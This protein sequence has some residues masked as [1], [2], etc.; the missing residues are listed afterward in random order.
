[1]PKTPT[2]AVRN[3]L[4]ITG[5]S[6]RLK[7]ELFQILTFKNPAYEDARRF[8][9]YGTPKG[10]PEV[11]CLCGENK[12][13]ELLLPRGT[14][15][16]KLSDES[17]A[18]LDKIDWKDSRVT[19]PVVFPK[20]LLQLNRE[21][22]FLLGHF[23][24]AFKA[25]DRPFG[26][27]LMVAPTSGGK[28]ILQAMIARETKQ[29]TLVLFPTNLA[30]IAWEED[31]VKLFGENFPVGLI[32][33]D[34][35]VI[36]EQFTLASIATLRE[37]KER[38]PEI[39]LK[40]GCVIVDETQFSKAPSYFDFLQACPAKY[41][42]SASATP[43][44][45]SANFYVTASFGQPLK[46]VNAEQK[47]TETS[48]PLSEV[49]LIETLFTYEYEKL[50]LDYNDLL[51]VMVTDE[52]RNHFFLKYII[53]ELRAGHC[54]L[55]VSKRKAHVYVIAQ[56]LL[57]AGISDYCIITGDTPRPEV[58]RHVKALLERKKRCLIATQAVIKVAANINPLDRLF[59]VTPA[60]SQ[61]VEQ[62]VGR[63]R[64]KSPG[65]TDAKMYYVFDKR[66]GYLHRFFTKEVLAALHKL[67]VKNF[68]GIA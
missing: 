67:R 65:K 20:P 12:L 27:I 32:Q 42:V 1:M 21:Q 17:L 41:L 60:N 24:I 52:V 28:T 45:R 35:W 64:R 25:N 68:K 61:D 48:L 50:E 44:A 34:T 10:I 18:E 3:K 40:F 58:K 37:R 46:T 30:R 53:K 22:N 57:E 54:P 15:F 59:L 38:W 14:D 63:I 55:V 2:G 51:D 39:F 56:M 9:P 36:E 29:R 31:L 4:R 47:E 23:R 8:S 43:R 49:E 5:A 62:L 66:V 16:L 26:N 13:G 33:Q 6:N 7:Q 19:A 11:V